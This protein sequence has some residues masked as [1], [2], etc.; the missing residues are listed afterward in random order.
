V[1]RPPSLPLR[2]HQGVM[3]TG[4]HVCDKDRAAVAG[5][6]GIGILD[7]LLVAL[8]NHGRVCLPSLPTSPFVPLRHSCLLCAG[9]R[10]EHNRARQWDRQERDSKATLV[11]GRRPR[12]GYAG[13]D[14]PCFRLLHVISN[15]VRW[16]VAGVHGAP[17]RLC[18]QDAPA[19]WSGRHS[20]LSPISLP[21]N[22]MECT[23]SVPRVG[24]V[25]TLPCQWSCCPQ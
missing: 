22:P 18:E 19:G 15:V 3:G 5:A 17:S 7:V 9:R 20:Y 11:I 2:S 21:L 12:C 4:R 1:Q 10:Q 8:A 16:R 25:L 23:F 24:I 14:F 6:L 13:P